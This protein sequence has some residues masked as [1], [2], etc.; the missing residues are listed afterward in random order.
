MKFIEDRLIEEFKDWEVF[1]REE[2]FD[3]YRRFE[4]D[5]KAGTLGWRIY[6]LKKKNIIKS[7]RR[8][9]YTISYQQQYNPE[10]TGELMKLAKVISQQFEDVRYCLWNLDW[11]NEFSQHQSTKNLI[12]IEVEKDFEDSLYFELKDAFQFDIYLNPDEKVINLYIAESQ[13]PIVIKKIISRSPLSERIE[14][15]MKFYVPRL[16]KI[17]VDL[18]TERELFYFYQGAELVHI[19]ENVLKKYP[20]NYTSLFSYAR[21]RNQEQDIK[22]FMNRNMPHLIKDIFK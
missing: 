14:K 10:I 7:V 2:L 1:S 4:P 6:N 12:M 11:V 9:Y 15:G 3:F 18:F 17:L 19:Y 5:L 20:L 13:N 8:G 22:D 21:R 16:E